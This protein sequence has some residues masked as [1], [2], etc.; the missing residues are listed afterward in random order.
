MA[1]TQ[2]RRKFSAEFKREAVAD[3]R[4]LG[5]RAAGRKH[6]V[7]QVSVLK[8]MKIV[9]EGK[10]MLK[11]GHSCPHCGRA[12]ERPQAFASHLRFAHADTL[13]S[14]TAPPKAK[15]E[16]KGHTE[17]VPRSVPVA[18]AVVPASALAS[19]SP[20]VPAIVSNTGAH[21]HLKTA[22]E[23]LMQRER[24][25]EEELSRL[26]ALQAEKETLRKQIDAVNSALQAFVG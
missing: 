1:K 25:I 26:T 8:W 13:P 6:G 15:K 22:L 16:K 17:P 14:K 2:R 21:E 19:V 20:P 3:A 7:S 18:V 12:F 9:N 24:Q 5:I 4:R 11:A 23:G 10:E